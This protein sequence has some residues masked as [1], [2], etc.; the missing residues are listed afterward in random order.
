M[1]GYLILIIHCINKLREKHMWA[2][3]RYRIIFDNINYQEHSIKLGGVVP[4]SL[5]AFKEM[6]LL[7]MIYLVMK[8][9]VSCL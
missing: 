2:Y 6:P 1:V 5:V 9:S 8:G 3:N 4:D 7:C